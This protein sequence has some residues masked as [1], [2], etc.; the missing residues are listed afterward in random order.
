MNLSESEILELDEHCN[1]MLDGSLDDACK[2][3]LCE[4]LLSSEEAR[5]FYVRA[6]PQSASLSLYAAL[7]SESGA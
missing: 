5:Q 1:A 2:A 7:T 3:T 4:R 6:M